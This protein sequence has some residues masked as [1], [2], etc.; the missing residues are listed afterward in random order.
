MLTLAIVGRP[1]VGKSTLFNRLAGKKLAIVDDTPGVTRDW[2]TAEANLFGRAMTIIDT[3]GLEESFDNSI[4]GRM[5]KQTEAGVKQ[6]DVIL[7]VI[8]G[9]QGLTA[10]D[11]H[12]AEWLRRQKKPVI[13]AVNKCEHSKSAAS[14]LAEAHALGLGEPVPISAEHGDGMELLYEMLTPHFPEETEEEE[15]EESQGDDFAALDEI[16]GKED[17]EFE[18]EEEDPETPLKIA[19]VGRPNVGKSTLLNSI[20]NDQRVMTGPEAGITRDAI[21]VDWTY[22]GRAFKLVDTAGMRK[23]ARVQ[24]NIEKMS[25]E[26]SLRAIRLAQ[27]VILVVDA[28][29]AFEKQ[30]VQIAAHVIEEGRALVVAINKWDAA[31]D[32]KKLLEEIEYG[33]QAQLAQVKDLPLVTISALNNSNIDG[34][35]ETVLKTYEIWNKR[36]STAGLNRWLRARESQNPA[37]LANGRANR[38]KYI[39]QVKTRPPTFAI[40]VSKPDA[41]PQTHKRYIINSLRD[42]YD[43]PGVPVRLLIRASKNPYADND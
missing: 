17:F 27:V 5:R 36:I 12:F 20:V 31:N 22:Q 19:I 3:A 30:D 33:L 2:R 35:L 14:G 4:Q 21:A 11:K 8:D 10:M 32:R 42:D 23:K 25:V 29:D 37:P 18:Q 28:A 26:D 7:F 38:L 43:I 40:W 13:L 1:N 6:A 41:L 39:T 9:R 34:L 15:T 16:E 24:N